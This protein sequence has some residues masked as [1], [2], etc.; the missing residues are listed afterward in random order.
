MHDQHLVVFTDEDLVSR[1]VHLA[2]D[3]ASPTFHYFFNL[4]LKKNIKSLIPCR[5]SQSVF[6][7]DLSGTIDLI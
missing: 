4:N 1:G 3:L 6:W 5:L 7:K 2:V